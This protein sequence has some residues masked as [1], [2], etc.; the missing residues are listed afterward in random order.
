M[1]NGLS[2]T[3]GVVSLTPSMLSHTD[4]M[5]RLF[6]VL[7][8]PWLSTVSD[9]ARMIVVREYEDL[10]EAG[11]AVQHQLCPIGL[12]VLDT[13][14]PELATQGPLYLVYFRPDA[15]RGTCSYIKIRCPTRG[16]QQEMV[17]GSL[18]D[19]ITDPW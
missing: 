6:R 17:T 4:L 15:I 16:Y 12:S 11:I 7:D 18:K 1:V 2:S 13:G 3:M 9:A 8:R 10:I 14:D 19:M 5:K